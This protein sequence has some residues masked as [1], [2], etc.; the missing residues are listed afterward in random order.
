M[1][2]PNPMVGEAEFRGLKLRM[3]FDR[4]CALEHATGRKMPHL[5]VE[6]ERGL[7]LSDLKTWFRC[8]SLSDVTDEQLA[9]TIHQGAMMADYEAANK[10]L[11]DM[12]NAFFSPSKETED[13]PLKAA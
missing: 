6:F 11:G 2:A 7:G 8:F 13:R 9:A 4:W 1:T 3:D 12:M 5:C 10:V